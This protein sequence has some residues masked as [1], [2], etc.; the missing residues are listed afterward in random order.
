MTDTSL[1]ASHI[2]DIRYNGLYPYSILS[3]L[4]QHRFMFRGVPVESVEGV[5]QGLKFKDPTIQRYCFGLHGYAAKSAGRDVPW[6]DNG[7]YYLGEPLDRFSLAYQTLLDELYGSVSQLPLFGAILDSTGESQLA[8]SIGKTSK[9]E[10]ILT[11]N[12]YVGR[13]TR[14]RNDRFQSD[15]FVF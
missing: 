13:L 6:W 7:L 11:I 14:I 2:I 15:I 12:E 8:H 10:T 4:W 1:T 5:L 9:T 3:N